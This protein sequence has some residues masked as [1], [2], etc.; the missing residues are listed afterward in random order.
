MMKKH[1][2]VITI[3]VALLI[4]ITFSGSD[5]YAKTPDGTWISRSGLWWFRYSNNEYAKN[6]YIDGYWMDRD[7]LYNSAWNGSWASDSNGWWFQ[8]GSW[9]P[10]NQWLKIDGSWYYF[11][12]DGYMASGEW[13]GDYYLSKDGTLATEKWIGKYY[14]GSDGAWVSD[15]EYPEDFTAAVNSAKV[16]TKDGQNYDMGKLLSYFGFQGTQGGYVKGNM[17]INPIDFENPKIVELKLD[18]NYYKINAASNGEYVFGKYSLTTNDMMNIYN[19]I[20]NNDTD[21]LEVQNNP[22]KPTT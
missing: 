10:S 8:S 16:S 6:E 21:N 5:S 22:H 1:F 12:A 2:C 7:G 19:F 13:A 11:K 4:A 15:K 3:L 14:V 17:C 9:Y 20:K 18:N